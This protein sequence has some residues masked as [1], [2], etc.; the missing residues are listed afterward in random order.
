MTT[1]RDPQESDIE[2]VRGY[3]KSKAQT[4]QFVTGTI[5]RKRRIDSAACIGEGVAWGSTRRDGSWSS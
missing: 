3:W 2:G 4:G 1:A 5:E